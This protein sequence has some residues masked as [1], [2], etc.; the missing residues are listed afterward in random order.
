MP[1]TLSTSRYEALLGVLLEAEAVDGAAAFP[2]S[3]LDPLRRAL[4]CDAASYR[5]WTADGITEFGLAADQPNEW[6]AAWDAYPH[7]RSDDPLPGG[8]GQPPSYTFS[9][10]PSEWLGEPL[11]ISDFLTARAFRQTGLYSVVC[12]P[13]GVRDVLKLFV[14]TGEAS[15][16]CFVL[17]STQRRFTQT[18][19]QVLRRLLPHLVQLR[20]NAR[21]R[22]P[23][24]A[25]TLGPALSSSRLRLLTPRE[26]EVLAR[27]ARGDT[28]RAIGAALFISPDTARKHLEHIYEK[29]GV[30]NRTEAAAVHAGS[31]QLQTPTM[32][33]P[34]QARSKDDGSIATTDEQPLDPRRQS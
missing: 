22:Q 18:D 24:V 20:R 9:V 12:K 3:F 32:P 8:P 16:A 26:Q 34:L 14:P 17:D 5:T 10:P 15:A 4:G 1:L 2:P 11:A 33:S 13:V 28:N 27:A 25:S 19:R 31:P 6:L 29:L 30:R 7:V 23:Q 21:L